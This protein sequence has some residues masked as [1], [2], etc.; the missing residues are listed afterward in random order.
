[1][2][3]EISYDLVM[4]DDMPFVEGTFLLPGG[5]WQVVIF[6]AFERDMPEPEVVPQVWV[7]GVTG[8]FVRYPRHARLNQAAVERVL[9][10][11][12]GVTEW[13]QVRGPD[14]MQIR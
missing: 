11:A 10:A 7:S 14:S 1:M 3:V 9:S 6:S 5:A 12:L 13:V 2:R 8:V 4:D